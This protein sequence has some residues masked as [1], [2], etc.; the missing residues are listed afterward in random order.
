[1]WGHKSP[2]KIVCVVFFADFV[3]KKYHTDREKAAPQ[4]HFCGV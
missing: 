3:G 2:E 1:V 4:A